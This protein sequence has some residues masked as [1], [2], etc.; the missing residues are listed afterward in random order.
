MCVCVCVCACV[1][2]WVLLRKGAYVRDVDVYV[3]MCALVYGRTI[4][5]CMSVC[6]FYTCVRHYV[7]ARESQHFPVSPVASAAFSRSQTLLA[8]ALDSAPLVTG[9]SPKSVATGGE[10]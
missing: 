4:G 9:S 1:R 7:V 2:K 10:K 6:V 3:C 5:V 8:D